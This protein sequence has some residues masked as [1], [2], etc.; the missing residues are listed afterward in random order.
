MREKALVVELKGE[1]K[2]IVEVARSTA[3][4]NCGKCM[5]G[6]ENLT[7]KAEVENTVGA[8]PGDTVDVEME[9]TGV[10][11][12]S[13]IVYGIPFAGFL[14]GCFLGYYWLAKLLAFSQDITAICLGALLMLLCYGAI[15]LLDKKGVFKQRF[16]IK[17]VE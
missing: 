11:S 13:I 16:I 5:V 15:K 12:A 17:I 1:N 3:C 8:K 2:A 14:G 6:K 7:V 4:E 9:L 10:L